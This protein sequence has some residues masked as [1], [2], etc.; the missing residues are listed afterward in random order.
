MIIDHEIPCPDCNGSGYGFGFI[1]QCDRCGGLGRI[2]IDDASDS[3]IR[4][5]QN[6]Y[7]DDDDF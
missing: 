1:G 5:A 7:D 2:D 6:N 4:H 3:E